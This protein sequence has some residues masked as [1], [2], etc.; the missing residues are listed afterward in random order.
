MSG[1]KRE[2]R[3]E[4]K[5]NVCEHSCKHGDDASADAAERFC[6]G[7]LFYFGSEAAGVPGGVRSV[8]KGPGFTDLPECDLRL[9][10]R[11]KKRQSQSWHRNGRTDS[12][13]KN[14]SKKP[15]ALDLRVR[16]L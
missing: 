1:V 6:E 3:A 11:R 13:A 2:V 10:D 9:A 12:L 16:S 5:K 14:A 7:N 15:R 8:E 4:G